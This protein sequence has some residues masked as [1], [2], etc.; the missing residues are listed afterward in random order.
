MVSSPLSTPLS[1]RGLLAGGLGLGALGLLSACAGP[2]AQ[3]DDGGSTTVG[4][5]E[6]WTRETGQNGTRQPL[7]QARLAAFDKEFGTQTAAQ[8]LVFAESVQKTQAALAAGDPPDLGQQGPDVALS[9]A[10]AGDLLDVSDVFEKLSPGFVPL[11][12]DAFVNFEDAYYSIPFYFETRVLLYH[13]DVFDDLG[14]DPPTTW[15]EWRDAAAAATQGEDRFGFAFGVE[16]PGPG[17]LLMPLATS[18]GAS[19]I[20]ADGTVSADT[21]EHR[22]ALQLIKG[23]HDDGSMPAALPT[24]KNNDVLQ[25][26][27]QK[28]IAMTWANAETLQGS[29]ALDPS[30]AD[31]VGAVLTPVRAAGDTSR[32]FL[33]GFQLFAFAAS[34]EPDLA[35]ELIAWMLD[36]DWY[37]EFITFTGGA[38]LP[39]TETVAA[40]PLFSESEVLSTIT[41]QLTTAVR[42][43]G[44][45]FGNAPWIGEAEGNG[46]FAK[47]VV[48]VLTGSLDVDASIL[49][50]DA[51]LKGTAGQ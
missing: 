30:L 44:T 1:R 8:Y 11:E 16:G 43:G 41:E 48:D 3:T 45:E 26:F 35:K 34:E 25:L 47:A 32:S 33:G 5:L 29:V 23:M 21:D 38:A 24:Y 15:D 18:A 27:T 14:I 42:Y 31:T 10:S 49:R 22:E 36:D 2:V 28:K 50:L 46:L 7:V 13:K 51:D 6:F 17:Q 19:L 40:D 12:R 37:R 9:F 39:V 4:S 20:S